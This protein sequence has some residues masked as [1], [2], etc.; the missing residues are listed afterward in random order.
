MPQFYCHHAALSVVNIRPQ[1]SI[2]NRQSEIFRGEHSPGRNSKFAI[3][4]FRDLLHPGGRPSGGTLEVP[5]G[6]TVTTLAAP[7]H[8][9]EALIERLFA[10]ANATFDLYSVY[11]GER[12]GLYSVLA[13]QGPLTATGLA[14]AAGIDDRYAREWLEQQATTGFVVYENGRFELPSA[15][16]AVLAHRDDPSYFAPLSRMIVAAGG[17]LPSLI[18]AFGTG[19]GIG[20][21]EYGLDMIEGQSE[22]NRPMFIHQLG[23]DILPA[24][25]EVHAALSKPGAR[26]AEVGFGGGWAAIGIANAYPGATVDGFDPDAASVEIA[27][28]NAAEAALSGRITFHGVD[29][30]Q[31]AATGATY[32]LVCAFECIHDMSN[33]VA[34]LESMRKLAGPTGHVL[35]MDERVADAFTGQSDDVERFM[36][37]WSVTTCLPNGRVD[38]PSAATGTVLRTPTLESYAQQAGF[39]RV[40]TLPIANDFFKF[41][42]LK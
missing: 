40:E 10:A 33:P 31:A 5:G 8:T 24:I 38:Y 11:L 39:Q 29:G 34:V 16:A 18:S 20:W 12:L 26:V 32:D 41:Y 13:S 37:G 42:L 23:N 7:T 1:P 28:R 15:H 3:R 6:A 35:V 21:D 14:E 2:E 27:T 30:A 4:N 19:D 22:L 17:K 9:S 36:Y 25:P